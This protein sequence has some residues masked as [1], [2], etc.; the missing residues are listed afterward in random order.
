[1]ALQFV[2][3]VLDLY[4]GS[5][6]P[7]VEGKVTLYPNVTVLDAADHVVLT[8]APIVVRLFGNPLPLVQ[9]V[10]TDTAGLQPTGWGWVIQPDFP[11][12]PPGGV[13]TVAFADGAEQFLSGLLPAFS[14]P[15]F[16]SF[17]PSS[18]GTYDGTITLAGTPPLI[19]PGATA[20]EVLVSDGSGNFTPQPLT[21]GGS[22]PAVAEPVTGDAVQRLAVPSYFYPTY[23]NPSGFWQQMQA[24]APY[25]EICVIN[26]SSGP[27]ISSNSDYVTQT[28][29][30]QAAGMKVLGYVHTE[31]TVVTAAAIEAQIDD[32]Y[33]WYG[34]DGVFVDET[35]NLLVNQ[36][37]YQGLYSYVK[38]KLTGAR[39]VVI[40]PGTIPDESYMAAC[41][42]C[43]NC[44]TDMGSYRVRAAAN[45]EIN[46]PASRFWHIIYATLSTAQRDEVLALSRQ[47]RAGYVY[48]TNDT[49]PN[50]YDTLAPA[51]YW[52]G[53][54]SQI[55]APF[56]AA[57]QVPVLEDGFD[58]T[59]GNLN[60]QW[61]TSG[62]VTIT[63]GALVIT[64]H[65]TYTDNAQGVP[66]FSFAGQAA[67]V[68][69]PVVPAAASGEA[70]M[71]VRA[72]ST[73]FLA[74]GKSGANLVL[75]SCVS[76]TNSDTTV[77]YSGTAHLW[78][79]IALSAGGTATW[80]TSPDN[81]TW[82]TQRTVS[83]GL[84]ALTTA[85]LELYV[86]HFTGGDPDQPASFDNVLVAS[87]AT[88]PVT[89]TGG[90][91]WMPSVAGVP[92]GTPDTQGY[93]VPFVTD[94]LT[95][96]L[97]AFISGSW[98]AVTLS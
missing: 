97:F 28:R 77:T 13:F 76:G 85:T 26:P 5:G 38:A 64:G 51:P 94:E 4:D 70:F 15:E 95:G 43:C 2:D 86:G 19:V 87:A 20:F 22:G 79:R 67:T 58:Q 3:L 27:G 12:A 35:S 92:T 23:F 91:A 68:E 74:I 53:L 73:N 44:E 80:Q 55:A 16:S 88:L 52:A 54:V 65:S 33:N 29:Q 69:V 57:V 25:A 8:Q 47:Y 30:A 40:N 32:Y 14:A 1:M 78:W 72:S 9:I 17:V 45:W 18:G 60:S 7:I 98:R 75:R 42:I 46:Y 41:D 50:P 10:A 62:A 56:P 31:Y 93:G 6:S 63:S 59:G 96:Q 48:I 90:F 21:G 89:A 34:V 84:P 83:S 39:L 24:A 71:Q 11:G 66:V 81:A 49:D 36:G 37:Y 82:T 61:N